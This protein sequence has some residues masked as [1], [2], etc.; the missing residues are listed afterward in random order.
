VPA[1][2][3]TSAAWEARRR[4]L[5]ARENPNFVYDSQR[6]PEIDYIIPRCLGGS[7]ELANM[8]FMSELDVL[9]RERNE[10]AACRAFCAG[11]L[12]LVQA[13]SLF[14]PSED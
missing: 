5:W 13:R 3:L 1:W 9:L 10:P 14:L 6:A 7:N 4:A 12:N 8:Q 2:P 11:T